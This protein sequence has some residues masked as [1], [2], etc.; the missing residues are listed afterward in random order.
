[1]TYPLLTERQV[2]DRLSDFFDRNEWRSPESQ[3]L[4]TAAA[5]Y[6]CLREFVTPP[7]RYGDKRKLVEDARVLLEGW[8]KVSDETP[9]P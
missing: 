9:T 8:E 4:Q 3:A 6:E 1:M 5:L 7:L 2:I